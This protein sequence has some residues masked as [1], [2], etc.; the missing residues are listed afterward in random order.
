LFCLDCL[1]AEKSVAEKLGLKDGRRLLVL[2]A[3]QPIAKL[4]GSIP[5]GAIVTEQGAETFPL[6]LTFARDRA[7]M[8]E[9]LQACR[10]KLAKG[11]ALWIAYAKGGSKLATD[12][13]RDTIREYV[14][15]VGFDTVAQ[16]AIDADWSALRLKLA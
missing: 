10:A 4:L 11:G 3:P 8:I 9:T 2:H 13:N 12:I 15:T 7:A 14:T 16:I 6:I 1:M 5:K